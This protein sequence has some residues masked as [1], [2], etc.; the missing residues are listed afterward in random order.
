MHSFIKIRSR[1]YHCRGNCSS[2]LRISPPSSTTISKP[3]IDADLDF[4][5]KPTNETFQRLILALDKLKID[6][7]GLKELIFDP[8]KTFLRVPHQG[9]HTD[10]LPDMKGLAP[11]RECKTNAQGPDLDGITVYILSLEDLILNKKAVNRAVDLS[12]AEE[13]E[14]IRNNRERKINDFRSSLIKK[15]NKFPP[16]PTHSSDYR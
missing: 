6:T 7:S 14:K 9:F 4:W 8:K 13:L 16:V 11:S 3:E 1:I 10:F 12:D 2:V 5:Y 15:L